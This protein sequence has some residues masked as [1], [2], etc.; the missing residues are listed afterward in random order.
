MSCRSGWKSAFLNSSARLPDSCHMHSLQ[1]GVLTSR[2]TLP[3]APTLSANAAAGEETALL[4]IKPGFCG[5]SNSFFQSL[6]A[7]TGNA[8]PMAMRT[9]HRARFAFFIISSS[10][11]GLVLEIETEHEVGRRRR[12][13][14]LVLVVRLRQAVVRFRIDAGELRPQM[15]VAR[16]EDDR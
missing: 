10:S 12:G 5:W 3:S 14:E 15:Q 9:A 6:H 13:L 8:S 1:S 2:F 16:G 4:S 11:R 7:A